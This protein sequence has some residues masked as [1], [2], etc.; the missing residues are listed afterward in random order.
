MNQEPLDITEDLIVA[1]LNGETT[2]EQTLLIQNWIEESYENKK[3]VDDLRFIWI[4]SGKLDPKPVAVNIDKAWDSLFARIEKAEE[5][6][7]VKP[8]VKKTIPLYKTVLKIAAVLVPIIFLSYLFFHSEKQTKQLAIVT[9]NAT[10]SKKLDD[11]SEININAHSKFEYPE[12]FAKK[13]R[14]VSLNGEAFFSITPNKAKPFIIHSDAVSIK[15]VGTSFNVKTTMEN[16][17]VYVKTGK[18]LLYS[19]EKSTG[20]TV[21]MLLIPGN[22][23]I[24]DRKTNTITKEEQ[25]NENDLFWK[26]K[27]MVFTKAKLSE[28]IDVL[29]KNYGVSIILKNPKLSE[30]RLNARFENQTIESIIEIIA[31]SLQVEISKTSTTSFEIDEKSN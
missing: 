13:T 1:F 10:T 26:T 2:V 23:G 24:Y 6:E 27:T 4:E 25:P 16:V 14:E 9:T 17:E 7:E 18:V 28:V 22:K 20:D 15:V 3:Q 31:T 30:L 5:I 21:S 19:I 29:Q 12:N 8:S 11:G